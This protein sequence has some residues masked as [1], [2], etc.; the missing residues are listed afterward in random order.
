[1][2]FIN[3]ENERETFKKTYEQNTQKNINQVYIIEAEHGVGKTEFIKEVSKYFANC[4]LEI[5][6]SDIEELSLF[7]TMVLELD[8]ASVNYGYDDFRTFYDKKTLT[9]KAIGLLLR[10]TAIFGQAWAKNKN[11]EMDF[12]SLIV[13]SAQN[14]KFILN[15]QIENLFEYAKIGR[16]HV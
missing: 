7:K 14:E 13:A 6:Q 15:A 3:R 10:I 9:D 16:A 11:Y 5:F 4:P 8:K 2:L 1:M 12:T